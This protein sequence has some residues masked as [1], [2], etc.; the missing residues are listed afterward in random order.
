MWHFTHVSLLP[1]Q[2]TFVSLPALNLSFVLSLQI[3]I[4]IHQ[5]DWRLRVLYFAL[6]NF[7]CSS[8]SSLAPWAEDLN[9]PWTKTRFSRWY[10]IPTFSFLSHL[11]FPL[12]GPCFMFAFTLLSFS[13]YYCYYCCVSI[14]MFLYTN[15]NSI[16]LTEI[17]IGKSTNSTSKIYNVEKSL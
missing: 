13:Y 8:P 14:V 16:L 11:S 4:H 12:F 2:I 15:H 7:V 9:L 3:P 1:R 17:S 10:T 5:Q 6:C